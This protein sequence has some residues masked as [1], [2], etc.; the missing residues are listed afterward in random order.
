MAGVTIKKTDPENTI[1]PT[2]PGFYKEILDHMSDGVYFVDRERRILYWNE[3]AYRLT[4]YKAEE[5]LGKCCQDDILCHVDPAGRRLC[6]EGC[7][8]TASIGDGGL[9]QANVFLRHK[10]GRR[11][12]VNVRV[13]PIL[14]AESEIIGAI[15]IFSDDSAQFDERRKIEAMNRLAFLDHLTQLPNR[16]FLDMSVQTAL[17]EYLVHH[18]PFAVLMI[19]LDRFKRINDDFGH[20]CGDRALQQ[21][22][23]TLTGALRPTDIVGR[24]GGDEFLAIVRNVN[25]EVLGELVERCAALAAQTS[26]SSNDERLISLSISVGAALMHPG[27]SVEELIQRADDRMYRSKTGRRGGAATE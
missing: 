3:G 16:R 5:L 15:E 24:W 4:G 8:L 14:N 11:V 25:E 23:L 9:H 22:A 27:D 10:E 6:M 18:D 7:P 12:P 21:M 13:Q 1:G 19:D 2:G 17:N 20:S 26:I